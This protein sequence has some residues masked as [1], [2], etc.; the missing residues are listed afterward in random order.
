[1][2]SSTIG[3]EFTNSSEIL[4]IFAQPTEMLPTSNDA[5]GDSSSGQ[6]SGPSEPSR[7]SNHVHGPGAGR[8]RRIALGTPE[9]A[10]TLD[11]VRPRET[12]LII[13][14]NPCA[15]GM[16]LDVGYTPCDESPAR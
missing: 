10:A 8:P 2:N 14:R 16:A 3:R 4:V 7:I 13:A 15:T 11:P 9:F 1:M 5:S 12:L 6:H